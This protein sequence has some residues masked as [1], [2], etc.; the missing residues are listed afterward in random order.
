MASSFYGAIGL[1]GGTTGMLDDIEGSFLNNND[2]AIVIDVTNNKFYFYLLDSDSGLA[3]SSPTVISPVNNAGTKRWILIYSSDTLGVLAEAREWTAQQNFNE[4]ALTSSSNSVAWNLDTAQ[5]A[6][7]TMTE[8]TTIAAPTNMNAGGTYVLR[9]VQGSGP[10][11]LAWNA[12]FVWGTTSA[13]AAPT[14][15]G[16]VILISCYS[17]GT[18]MYAME[19]LREEA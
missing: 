18:N 14:A 2:G 10:Y 11:T 19:V 3:A 15:N 13:S 9:I 17:D 16:D 4:S 8:N 1:T 12:A 5:T 6:V 7:H